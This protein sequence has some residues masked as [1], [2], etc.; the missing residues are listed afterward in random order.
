MYFPAYM[1]FESTHSTV[2]REGT[3]AELLTIGEVPIGKILHR[4]ETV[5]LIYLNIKMAWDLLFKLLIRG[6]IQRQYNSLLERTRSI[7]LHQ[8]TRIPPLFTQ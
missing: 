4:L 1:D 5:L 3:G 2:S 8:T 6:K 7:R